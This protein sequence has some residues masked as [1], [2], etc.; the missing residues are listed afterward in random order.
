[1]KI[2]I[3]AGGFFPGKTFGG[4]PVSVDNFCSLMKG[5]DCFI[6]TSDHDNGTKDR[7]QAIN[8]GWNDRGNSKVLYLPDEEYYSVKRLDSIVKEVHP[9]IIYLQSLFQDLALLGLIVAKRNNIKVILAPR[10]ELCAG[11]FKKKYKKIPYILALRITGLIKKAHF[12]STSDEETEAINRYL[13][14]PYKKIHYLTNI[15]SIPRK[16]YVHPQKIQGEARFVFLSRIHPKKNLAFA[17]NCM[18]AIKGEVQFD[19]YGPLEDKD[20]WA[21]CKNI[22]KKLP[23]NIKV[24]YKGLLGHDDVHETFSQYDAFLFPTLSENYGHVIAESLVVGTPV[25]ISN[26]TPWND[27]NEAGAGW[28]I[29]LTDERQFVVAIQ[30]IVDADNTSMSDNALRFAKE[31]MKLD[32][33]KMLYQTVFDDLVKT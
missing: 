31:K 13:Q 12:Q 25:I 28:A 22:I 9:D 7:Y 21:E 24:E 16:A 23:D 29:P 17:L 5:Y 14:V 30:T 18:A 1:M 3:F 2:L 6:V 26:Q 19:I 20:Y 10:G 27:V 11:A 33:I 15:P 4:P 32:D 8:D